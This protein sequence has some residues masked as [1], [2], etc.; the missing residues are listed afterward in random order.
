MKCPACGL[1]NPPSSS[2]CDCG[3]GFGTRTGGAS[4]SLW[5]RYRTLLILLSPILLALLMWALSTSTVRD[6]LELLKWV[7]SAM[8]DRLER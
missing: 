1:L 5:K 7:L 6:R 4:L 8:L 3:Y 2:N